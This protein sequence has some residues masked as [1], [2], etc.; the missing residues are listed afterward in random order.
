[1]V[2]TIV[3]QFRYLTSIMF[4]F[5]NFLNR[6]RSRNFKR[7][8][9]ALN[10]NQSPQKLLKAFLFY[11]EDLKNNPNLLTDKPAM[12]T[13]AVARGFSLNLVRLGHRFS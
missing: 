7:F 1:M 12:N 13:Q 5:K 6:K 10:S 9:T 8:C 11:E 4:N 2:N 3:P